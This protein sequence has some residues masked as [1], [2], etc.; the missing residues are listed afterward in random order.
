M[1][2]I[3]IVGYFRVSFSCSR[4]KY[5]W[6]NYWNTKPFWCSFWECFKLYLSS[7]MH[8]FQ[9]SVYMGSNQIVP[10]TVSIPHREFEWIING[11]LFLLFIL[12]LYWYKKLENFSLLYYWMLFPFLKERVMCV[13]S[14][15]KRYIF[16]LSVCPSQSENSW[17]YSLKSTDLKV[18]NNF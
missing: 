5:T 16:C 4:R 1:L 6:N 2:L 3:A 12:R 17:V 13:L 7:E 9:F 18:P 15:E 10:N 14:G 11:I 8:Y